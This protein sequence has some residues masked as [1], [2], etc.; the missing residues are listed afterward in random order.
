MGGYLY[1]GG[2]AAAGRHRS[3]PAGRPDRYR[4][5]DDAG[6][7]QQLQARRKVD[8][9]KGYILDYQPL[10]SYLLLTALAIVVAM[11]GTAPAVRRT[12]FAG[13]LTAL[14]AIAALALDQSSTDSAPWEGMIR[15]DGFSR[16]FNIVFLI[17]LALVA[18]G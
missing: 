4:A 5:E 10:Y 13:W 14:G 16:A 7:Q 1:T 9:M 12:S 8:A 17:T 11:L 3:T 15:F 18:I 2:R 6:N